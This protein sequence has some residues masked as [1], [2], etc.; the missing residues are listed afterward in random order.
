MY[1][2][3]Q[4]GGVWFT[5]E[6]D[7]IMDDGTSYRDTVVSQCELISTRVNYSRQEDCKYYGGIGFVIQYNFTALHVAPI[8]QAIADEAIVRHVTGNPN[9][10]IEGTIAPL[11]V[12][13]KE[14]SYAK[15]ANTF[16]AWFLVVLSFP[17]IAG[18]SA[19]FIVSE[20]FSKAKHVQSVAGVEPSAYWLS[21]FI[22]DVINYQIPL[23]I[24]VAIMVAFH[25]DILTT[26]ERDVFPGVVAV[27]CLYGPASAGFTYCISFAFKSASLCNI[28]VLVTG[29]IFGMAGPLTC[30]LLMVRSVDPRGPEP[31]LAEIANILAWFLRWN[32]SF[33]LGKALFNVINIDMF[34]LI[35]KDNDLN[36][37]SEFILET[38]VYCLA[39]QCIVFLP[40][41]IQIDKW[42]TN[43][44]VM[45]LW[46]NFSDLSWIWRSSKMQMK[47]IAVAEQE[48]VLSGSA[49]NE[50]RNHDDDVV[51]EQELVLS[52]KATNNLICIKQLTKVYA[53]GKVALN[54]LS[55]GVAPGECFGLLGINGE[56]IIYACIFFI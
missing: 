35:T 2:A 22:W 52:G 51:A 45:S 33:C 29:F 54:N 1:A 43:P 30:F 41:A 56:H 21:T 46:Q 3:S 18:A 32:P 24:T 44:H 34:V 55:L 6:T 9:F 23:W 19:T 14:E 10:A 53:N 13:L 7:S 27:L 17:F 8:Y 11:P 49:T 26:K 39:V 37:W 36:A 20:R 15:P 40:L 25:V 12:T 42:S 28:T 5:H 47:S 16:A 4:Y 48:R 50:L 38:E 31:Q